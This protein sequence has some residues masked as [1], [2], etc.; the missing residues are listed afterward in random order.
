MADPTQHSRVRSGGNWT[1]RSNIYTE[2]GPKS[3]GRCHVLLA[4]GQDFVE[5]LPGPAK[6]VRAVV[7]LLH[8]RVQAVREFFLVGE[9][10]DAQS[11][12]LQNAE[13]LF[14]LIHPR[15]MHRRMMEL[16]AEMLGQPG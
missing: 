6:P 2:E 8:K 13:P 4:L 9:V 12:A 5:G 14:D 16:E 7:P 15:A 1:K 11:L 3:S 10:G